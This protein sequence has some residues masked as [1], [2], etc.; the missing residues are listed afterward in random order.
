MIATLILAAAVGGSCPK[1]LPAPVPHHHKHHKAVPLLQCTCVD[2]PP[3]TMWLTP[4][5]PDIEPIPLSV[6]P[7]YIPM[8]WDDP[9]LPDDMPSDYVGYWG[10]IG[11]YAPR[12][13]AARAPEIDPASSGAALT[14]LCGTLAVLRGRRRV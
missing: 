4:P 8:A 13:V 5:E 10:P 1:P 2:E 14:L 11:G 12:T 7:Y 6:Y 3:R 9:E